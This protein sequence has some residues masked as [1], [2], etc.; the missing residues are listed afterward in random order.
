MWCPQLVP[1]PHRDGMYVRK[2]RVQHSDAHARQSETSIFGSSTAQWY[3]CQVRCPRKQSHCQ[4]HCLYVAILA[5]FFPI[6]A[7]GSQPRFLGSCWPNMVAV[8]EALNRSPTYKP[9][10]RSWS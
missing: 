8:F 10:I 6:K 9:R 4:V 3:S 5:N 1:Q 7:P 2:M